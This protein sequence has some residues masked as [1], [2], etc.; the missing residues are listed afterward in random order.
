MA[1]QIRLFEK[2][3]DGRL[4]EVAPGN[5]ENLRQGR[6]VSHTNISID[7]LWTAEEEAARA[8]EET[9]SASRAKAAEEAQAKAAAHQAAIRVIAETKLKQFG[10]TPEEMQALIGGK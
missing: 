4:H 9:E 5:A 6:R 8:A 2:D 7:V 1:G 3:A 10:M